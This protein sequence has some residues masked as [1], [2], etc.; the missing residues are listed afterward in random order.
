MRVATRGGSPVVVCRGVCLNMG[1]PRKRGV[2]I[3]HNSAR[4]TFCETYIPRNK[5]VAVTDRDR[6]R[7]PE[8]PFS[9]KWAC[10]CCHGLSI[11]GVYRLGK[12]RQS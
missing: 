3:Y 9:K 10:P 2:S 1:K 4:C 8:T 5:L 11:K 12:K 6:Q 7:R